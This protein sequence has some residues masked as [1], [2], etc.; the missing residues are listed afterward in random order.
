[1]N[2]E[3]QKKIKNLK[4]KTNSV[5]LVHN[6]QLPEVQDIADFLGDSLDLAMKATKTNADNIIFCGVDFMAESAKI[7]N[8]EKNV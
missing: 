4:K 5:I 8:P 6:Y 1:M 3:I 2:Q 7:L